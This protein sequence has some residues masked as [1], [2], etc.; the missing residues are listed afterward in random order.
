MSDSQIP[1][2]ERLALLAEADDLFKQGGDFDIAGSIS[3]HGPRECWEE[4]VHS[5]N[6]AAVKYRD[7][8]LG[9]KAREA[10]SRSA[11]CHRKIAGEHLRFAKHCE[12]D[13]D[14]VEI[15]WDG[16]GNTHV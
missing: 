6:S 1:A 2:H 7:L 12:E 4:A 9:L 14:A 5:F 11:E 13:R 3:G 8:G 10:W 16:E 15:H